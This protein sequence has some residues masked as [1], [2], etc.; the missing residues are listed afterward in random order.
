MNNIGAHLGILSLK[1]LMPPPLLA[2]PSTVHKNAKDYQDGTAHKIMLN[3]L[4]LRVFTV[5]EAYAADPFSSRLDPR[6]NFHNIKSQTLRS[7]E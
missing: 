1:P 6:E 4:N 2:L 7:R 5:K 3:S